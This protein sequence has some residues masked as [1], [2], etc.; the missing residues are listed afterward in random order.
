MEFKVPFKD[1]FPEDPGPVPDDPQAQID[2]HAAKIILERLTAWI[3]E[4]V[5]R[6]HALTYA[7]GRLALVDLV[8][9]ATHLERAITALDRRQ[10]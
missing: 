4:D 6:L 7:T 3:A 5:H 8:T 1:P 9:V 10:P 2:L